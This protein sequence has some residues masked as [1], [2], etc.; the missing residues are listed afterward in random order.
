MLIA[1]IFSSIFDFFGADLS[2]FS[3]VRKLLLDLPDPAI[4]SYH[5]ES[6]FHCISWP[7]IKGQASFIYRAKNLGSFYRTGQNTAA[8]LFLSHSKDE[9]NLQIRLRAQVKCMD[10]NS[11]FASTRERHRQVYTYSV[12][13]TWWETPGFE[14]LANVTPRHT[15]SPFPLPHRYSTSK[16][17][18]QSNS[19]WFATTLK[20]NG[21]HYF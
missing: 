19:L 14:L 5:S 7:L 4:F 6:F 16:P 9:I 12:T 20:L 15:P 1:S 8:L 2:I 13:C 21:F 11:A 10:E 17:Q 3:L 18:P